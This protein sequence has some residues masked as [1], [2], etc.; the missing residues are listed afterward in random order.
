VHTWELAKE[1]ELAEGNTG[2]HELAIDASWTSREHAPVA[3]AN[4]GGVAWQL[5]QVLARLHALFGAEFHIFCASLQ[6]G[7]LGRIATNELFPLLL[8]DYDASLCHFYSPYHAVGLEDPRTP[9][10]F[11]LTS[12][13]VK[14]CLCPQVLIEA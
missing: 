10:L 6:F 3:Q 11:I 13:A 14:V 12:M 4:G 2:Q 1:S 5:G 9:A 8:A 7:P